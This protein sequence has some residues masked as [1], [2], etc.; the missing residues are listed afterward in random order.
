M[1]LKDISYCIDNMI[2]FI[3]ILERKLKL[4]SIE[5]KLKYLGLNLSRIPKSLKEF[6][7]LEFRI[8]KFYDDKQ[9]R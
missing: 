2:F 8:P 3:D 5:E 4:S 6:E 1:Q 9:H 7:P